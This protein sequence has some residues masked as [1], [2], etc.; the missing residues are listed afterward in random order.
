M[1]LPGVM[2]ASAIETWGMKVK[3]YG[4]P[5]VGGII[6]IGAI[7]WAILHYR[8]VTPSSPPDLPPA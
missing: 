2:A 7:A 5:L 3:H 8:K 4:W 6:V 1:V